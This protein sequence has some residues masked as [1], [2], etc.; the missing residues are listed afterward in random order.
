MPDPAKASPEGLV[1]AGA[2]LAP[3]T[4]LAAYRAGLFPWPD[5]EGRLLWWSPDPRAILPLERFHESRSLRRT[6]RL[7]RFEVTLDRAFPAVVAGCADRPEGTWI[8]SDITHGYRTLHRLGWA[9]SVEVWSGER[10]VGGLYGVA[11][12]GFFAAESMF[13]RERDAS[14]VALAELVERLASRGFRLLDVQFRTNHLESLGAIEIPRSEYLR[15][16]DAA[17]DA[18]I[19]SSAFAGDA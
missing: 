1:A 17:L 5:R 4:V 12:G 16:L 9:H 19:S 10:L 6:R 2:D 13:H 15:R 11:I 8:T 14:K 7:G 18:E 3:G